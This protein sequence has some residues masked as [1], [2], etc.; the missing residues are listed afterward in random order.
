MCLQ[1]ESLQPCFKSEC[2]FVG[3]HEYLNAESLYM[4]PGLYQFNRCCSYEKN[5]TIIKQIFRIK[6]LLVPRGC[7]GGLEMLKKLWRCCQS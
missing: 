7:M 1:K 6:V 2:T 3:M 4:M 5:Y